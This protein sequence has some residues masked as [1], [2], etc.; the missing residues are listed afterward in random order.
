MTW[1]WQRPDWPD[2]TWD[3]DRL[4]RAETLFA[5]GA[6]MVIGA[7]R[8]LDDPSRE[9]L[10][11]D[12]MS[13]DAVA[14]SA[15]EGEVLDRDSVQSSIR[16][17]LGLAGDR[18]SVGAAE[19]G[20]AEM[21][22]S[23]YRS[24]AEP[25]DH[26]RLHAWHRMLMNGRR[27]LEAIGRYRTHREPMQIVSGAVYAPRV[28]FEAPPS[29]QVQAEME[30]FLA[31]FE[32]TAPTG[33]RPLP[34]LTRAGLAHLWFESI[35]PFED[36]NGRIGRAI[37]E[38]ALAQGITPGVS[39]P[40]LTAVAGT[41]LK[42]RKPYYGALE[43]ASRALE[44]TDWLLWFAAKV[45]EAQRRS[46]AQVEFIIGKARLLERV[47]GKLNARQEKAVL[48][49]FAAGTDGFTGGLSAGNYRGITGATPATATRDLADLVALDVL[50]RTG[51]RKATR[52][53]L[54]VPLKPVATVEVDDLCGSSPRRNGGHR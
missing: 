26:D 22:V 7:S 16:R 25:L 38:K 50:Y 29:A 2:F 51:E 21:M 15:I 44:V 42:H 30:R 5:Q 20:I 48:R 11:V 31:W 19:A 43:A 32:D 47:R 12:L 53:H 49:M 4:T 8:H 3:Q 13:V 37:A 14:T 52:Y 17:Q 1:N 9:T 33:T 35:H 54:C 45:I 36:G 28:H 41:L 39:D 46:L 40:V 27:D 23:L 34:A 18:R 10:V 24:L 6:G